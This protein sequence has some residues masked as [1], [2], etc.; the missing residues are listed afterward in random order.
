[1]LHILRIWSSF[2]GQLAKEWNLNLDASGNLKFPNR[3][4]KVCEIKKPSIL[5]FLCLINKQYLPEVLLL[6]IP[7]RDF[8]LF[9]VWFCITTP[10]QE[11][12]DIL[13]CLCKHTVIL[14][15][16]N[17]EYQFDRTKIYSFKLNHYHYLWKDMISFNFSN[18]SN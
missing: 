4:H 14:L 11:F 1:M 12:C 16:R 2:Q 8:V 18:S 3:I 10:E 5:V 7:Q 17:N 15:H 6:H 9:S 13:F